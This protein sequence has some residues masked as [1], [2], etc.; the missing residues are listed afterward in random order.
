MTVEEFRQI[1]STFNESMFLTKVNNI[2]I[3]LFTSIMMDSLEDVD[4]FIG[5]DV[6]NFA[7]GIASKTRDTGN[8]QMYDELNVKDSTIQN[9]IVED[10][11]YVIKVYLQSRYMDYIINLDS[12]DLVSGNDQSRIQVD[13]L[14]TFTKKKDATNQGIVKKCPGC[15]ASLSVNT[16]G[17]CEY[18]GSIYNQEDYDWVLTGLEVC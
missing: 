17:K 1:D 18:C 8:R 4:H 10:N 5:N 6:M 11:V 2:F 7:E 16:T 13:Y 14:L 12:G 3:K 15:G 9:I